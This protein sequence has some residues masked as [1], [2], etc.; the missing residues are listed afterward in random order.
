MNSSNDGGTLFPRES[1]SEEYWLQEIRLR[2]SQGDVTGALMARHMRFVTRCLAYIPAEFLGMATAEATVLNY[3]ARMEDLHLAFP[4]MA[5]N[6]AEPY[7]MVH[8]I[9]K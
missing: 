6:A 1:A 8:L 3:L 7:G 4:H 5:R 2:T 9:P